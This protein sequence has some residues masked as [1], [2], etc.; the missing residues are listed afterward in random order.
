MQL[1]KIVLVSLSL[2]YLVG[3]DELI[4]TAQVANGLQVKIKKDKVVDVPAGNYRSAVDFSPSRRTIEIKLKKAIAGKD[5]TFK[6]KAPD[7][8]KLPVYDGDINVSAAESGQLFDLFARVDTDISDSAEYQATESCTTKFYEKVCREVVDEVTHQKHE[9]CNVEELSVTGQHD[10]RYYYTTTTT[11]G[12]ITLTKPGSD[13]QLTSFVGSR[14]SQSKNYTYQGDCWLR[15]HGFENDHLGYG[16]GG[17]G[18]W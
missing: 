17:R 18:R 4:G 13:I 8:L 10:V 3:C 7:S 14:S 1:S 12:R 9:E 6:V 5:L 2:A 15:G 16:R 11:S